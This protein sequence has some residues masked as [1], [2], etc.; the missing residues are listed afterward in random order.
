[1]KRASLFKCLVL[2]C[3]GCFVL[4]SAAHAWWNDDWTLRKKI[5]IDTSSN[6]ILVTDPIGTPVVLV[7]LSDFQFS[8]AKDDGSDIRFI[9]DDDKTPLAYH[10]EKYDS[11]MGEAFAWVKIPNLKPGTPTTLWLYYGN[12]NGTKPAPG[13]ADAKGT[14]DANTLLVYHFAGPSGQ[15]AT[16]STG[17]GNTAQN[18]G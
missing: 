11:L 2:A 6:G 18:T 9:A 16:D 3:L 4:P 10:F 15:P 8:A 5:T 7:R 1:M 12:A 17:N 13:A 14:Y